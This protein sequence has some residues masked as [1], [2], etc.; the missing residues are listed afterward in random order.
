MS[1][2]LTIDSLSV[3]Q[4]TIGLSK[5]SPKIYG[6]SIYSKSQN[7]LA[8]DIWRLFVSIFRSLARFSTNRIDN[9]LRFLSYTIDRYL[10]SSSNSDKNGLRWGNSRGGYKL[11]LYSHQILFDSIE[12]LPGKLFISI[13]DQIYI[14]TNI[15]D[16]QNL[17]SS[18]D[19]GR[20]QVDN[21]S[22][23]WEIE[24]INTHWY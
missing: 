10:I 12:K 4:M 2:L 21:R 14:K 18:S 20:N 23:N 15:D 3:H 11:F 24:Q 9:R 8:Y 5:N 17:G 6:I 13:Y 16:C 19:L 22:Y 1:F 7:C